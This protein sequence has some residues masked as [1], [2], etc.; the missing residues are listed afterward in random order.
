MGAEVNSRR[1]WPAL[2]V[3]QACPIANGMTGLC[4]T[5]VRLGLAKVNARGQAPGQVDQPMAVADGGLLIIIEDPD[6]DT[7]TADG[8]GLDS[9]TDLA[10]RS[11]F[12]EHR[13]TY[14]ESAATSRNQ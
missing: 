6:I 8:E 2:C 11:E 14:P 13:D 3:K 7:L 9:I 10:V 5:V 4:I 1:A 12:I